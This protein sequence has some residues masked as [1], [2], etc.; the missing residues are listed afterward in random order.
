MTTVR[1]IMS[2]QLFSVDPND[3]AQEALEYLQILDI[4]AAAVVE[5]R[6]GSS[7]SSTCC[8]PSS[9]GTARA[10]RRPRMR[11]PRWVACSGRTRSS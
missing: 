7:L 8:V 10:G 6:S 11:Q 1:E 3:P 5:V 9:V 4:H 2:P